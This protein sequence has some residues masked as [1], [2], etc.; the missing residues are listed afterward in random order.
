MEFIYG[1][2]NPVGGNINNVVNSKSIVSYK[3]KGKDLER[4][5]GHGSRCFRSDVGRKVIS[6][7][8]TKAQT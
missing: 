1:Q 7:S 3:T 8:G 4:G 5:G 2:E 6:E